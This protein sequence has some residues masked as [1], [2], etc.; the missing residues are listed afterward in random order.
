MSDFFLLNSMQDW[1]VERN[2]DVTEVAAEHHN[3]NT[4]HESSSTLLGTLYSTSQH[5]LL[6]QYQQQQQHY[7]RLKGC[8]GS[9]PLPQLY[10]SNGMMSSRSHNGLWTARSDPAIAATGLKG[11]SYADISE[12]LPPM[13]SFTFL[14]LAPQILQPSYHAPFIK[15][16]WKMREGGFPSPF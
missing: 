5:Q 16:M 13:R 4:P 6:W 11:D 7:Q 1:R 8:G 3:H 12:P 15:F 10:N 14:R 9:G 2:F